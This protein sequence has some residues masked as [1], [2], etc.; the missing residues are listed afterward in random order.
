MFTDEIIRRGTKPV[1]PF[2]RV[3]SLDE[4]D[5]ILSVPGVY[6][7]S[8]MEVGKSRHGS[9]VGVPVAVPAGQVRA[10]ACQP[11]IV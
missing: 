8:R 9:L 11:D 7:I 3:A 2:P 4:L 10:V 5:T 1:D 6:W